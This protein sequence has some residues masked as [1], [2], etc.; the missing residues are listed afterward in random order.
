MHP[1]HLLVLKT[2]RIPR[3]RVFLLLVFTLLFLVLAVVLFVGALFFQSYIYTEPTAGLAWRAPAAAG[4][5]AAFFTLWCLLV[6]RSDASPG[7]IPYDTIF[8][9]S[10]KVAMFEGPAPKFWAIR[11]DGVTKTPYIM[12]KGDDGRPEYVD[13]IDKK[14]RYNPSGVAAIELE[15]KG[16][17]VRF[18]KVAAEQGSNYRTFRSPDGWVMQEFE[19]GPT[20]EPSQSR[21]GRFFANVA[22]NV[23]HAAL[24]F[25]SFWLLLQFRFND[26]L[27]FALVISLIATVV[28]LP[29]ILD[30]AA[31]MAR[32]R[33]A[34]GSG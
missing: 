21:W 14:K 15:N 34:A 28:L 30:Q 31:A 19:N 3:K 12:R 33:V 4:L 25:V 9:F 10:P 2:R 29:M 23:L 27:G 11:P 18:E 17:T 1:T 8:R 20:G 24:W 6:A 5:M 32:D 26:A 16:A 7:N 22:L 13:A